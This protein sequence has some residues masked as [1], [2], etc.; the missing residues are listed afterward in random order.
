MNE[1]F[2]Q[3]NLIS[4]LAKRETL[5]TLRTWRKECD[6]K[7]EADLINDL[8]DLIVSGDLDG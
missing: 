3:E 2:I 1:R 4:T 7:I 5:A 8:L 6:S